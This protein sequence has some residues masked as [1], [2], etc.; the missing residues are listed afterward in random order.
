MNKEYLQKFY[1]ENK[2]TI[3][4]SEQ[5]IT[6]L[7]DFI[8]YIFVTLSSNIQYDFNLDID[9]KQLFKEENKTLDLKE[10]EIEK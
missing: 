8:D 1:K 10:E 2:E 9:K 7:D 6:S 5:D 4:E 3:L